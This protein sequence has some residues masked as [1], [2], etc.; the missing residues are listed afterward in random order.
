M[1]EHRDSRAELRQTPSGEEPDRVL[2]V[3]PDATQ[4]VTF[5][6]TMRDEP[7]NCRAVTTGRE[8]LR[9]LDEAPHAVLLVDLVLPDMSGMEFLARA[10][11]LRP[12]A[13]RVLVLDRLDGETVCDAVNKVG[14]FRILQKPWDGS[15][16]RNAVRR[17]VVQH[18]LLT[19]NHLMAIRL[20]EVNEKL[21]VLNRELDATVAERT[22]QLLLSLCNALDLRDTDTQ[23]HSRRVALYTRRLATELGVAGEELRDIER[24]ALLHDIGKIGV[25]DTILLKPGKLTE[26][27]WTAMRRHSLF[28]AQILAGIPF[29]LRARQLVA[30]HHER[31]DGSGYNGGL[32]GTQICIGARIFA[33]IDTFDAITSDRPYRKALGHAHAVAEIRKG[34]GTQFDPAVVAAFERVRAEE[35]E[36]IRRHSADPEVAPD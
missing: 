8:G 16:L 3:D 33:V 22:S 24:G 12:E 10:S 14:V 6:R 1:S 31:W 27:E 2:Y 15:Q 21:H 19:D 26:D 25:S 17:A 29:L 34:S 11:R 5:Q 7:V 18:R 23:W 13:V 35:W 4:L 9:L 28:G 36:E 20:Q 32:R 30:Q